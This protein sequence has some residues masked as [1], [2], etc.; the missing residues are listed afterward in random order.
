MRR[1]C[2]F[3]ALL[4]PLFALF[5]ANGASAQ[6]I[7]WLSGESGITISRETGSARLDAMGGLSIVVPDESNELNLSDYGENL[8]GML[9][10]S[11]GRRWE[12]WARSS[13]RKADSRNGSGVRTRVRD[14]V[15]ELGG[16][17][18]WRRPGHRFLGLEYRHDSFVNDV[19]QAEKSKIRGPWWGG[20]IG[21]VFG[22]FTASGSIRLQSDNE[23]LRTDNIFAVRHRS[24]GVHYTGALSY[25][26]GAMEVGL[27]MERSVVTIDGVSRDESR[28]HEDELT[29]RRP[30]TIY[31]GVLLW[32]PAKRVDGAVRVQILDLNGRQ[33]VKVS[34][35]DRMPQNPGRE[36]FRTSAGTFDEE[37]SGLSLGTRWQARITEPLLVAMELE[38]SQEEELVTEG[39]NY[40]GS[41]RQLDIERTTTRAT[42]GAGYEL[43]GGRLRIG[44]EGSL[45]RHVEEERLLSGAIEVTSRLLGLHTGVEYFVNDVVALRA[46]LVRVAR[47]DDLD[48]P[49]TLLLGNA[50][51]FGA[52]YVPRGGLVQIDLGVGFRDLNPDYDGDPSLEESEID[53]S[54]TARL[55]L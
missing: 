10:D 8:S 50:L 12:S 9:R 13:E 15:T 35:S 54:L 46:G 44:V 24:S 3:G 4:C 20:M 48:G 36:N 43:N 47:D 52:G 2:L 32:S 38:R 28:F 31:S 16:R 26:A 21:Q 27:Q 34:W 49:R 37:I 25:L 17:I 6:A 39:H 40:K 18:T 51:T 22:P 30:S 29:W 41:R 19:E 5:S 23:D 14:S 7:D 1:S 42:A 53:L 55:L 33:E 11:D 45:T